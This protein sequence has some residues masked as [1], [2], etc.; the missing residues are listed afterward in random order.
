MIKSLRQKNIEKMV[1]KLI[2][3]DEEN[4][5]LNTILKMVYTGNIDEKTL[6]E[7]QKK[8]QEDLKYINE[9][10]EILI[11]SPKIISDSNVNN[12]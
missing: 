11:E 10:Y 1:D 7:I 3:T 2:G 8:K 12:G 6:D 9:R 5:D 4:S